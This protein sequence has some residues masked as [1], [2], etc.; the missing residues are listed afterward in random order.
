MKRL[1][2][3]AMAMAA[4]V[5]GVRAQCIDHTLW[6]G[7]MA[8]NVDEEGL[9]DYDAIRAG[10]GGNIGQYLSL[11]GSAQLG[12]CGEAEKLA[13]WINAYNANMIKKILDRPK[14]KKVSE[15]FKIFDEK[16]KVAGQNLSLNEIENRVIRADP[17]K[18]GPIPGVS[19]SHFDS[20][21][22][23]ALVCGAISCPRLIGRAYRADDLEKQLQAN[24]IHFA[25]APKH[26]RVEKGV[27]VLST[28]LNWYKGDFDKVG[29]VKNFLISLI[30]SSKRADA[31]EVIE[32]LKNGYPGKVKYE[33]DWTLNSIKNKR[34]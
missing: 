23:F 10:R 13:F 11:L 18:G 6:Q 19:L 16:F 8:A 3:F 7:I 30:D 4:A 26:V 15:D 2:I 9:V 21:V 17:A 12:T 32:S 27:L 25:N 24:A 34:K 31:A 22:H 20:R 28:L 1:F 14:L 5:G 29:G 33:Y